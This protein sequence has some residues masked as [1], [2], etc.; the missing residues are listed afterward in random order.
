[1]SKRVIVLGAGLSG[2]SAAFSLV[3][4]GV[5]VVILE[6]R[7]RVGGRVETR[8]VNAS[9]DEYIFEAGAEWVGKNDRHILQMAKDFDLKLVDHVFDF[10]LEFEGEYKSQG[11][12]EFEIQAERKYQQ[13]LKDFVSGRLG[14]PEALDSISFWRFLAKNGFDQ[15][16]LI[17]RDLLYSSDFGESIRH[18]SAY[19]VLTVYSA[20][21]SHDNMDAK[22]LDGNDLLPKRLAEKI[23]HEKILL[24]SQVSAVKQSDKSVEVFSQNGGVFE[25]DYLICTLP[26]TAMLK[27]NWEPVFPEMQYDAM[28]KLEYA[29]VTKTAFVTSRKVVDKLNFALFTDQIP[30]VIY[31]GNKY[32]NDA[33]GDLIMSYSVGERADLMRT[34]SHAKL[35]EVMIEHLRK[36]F[37]IEVGELKFLDQKAW[38][39]DAYTAGAYSVFNIGHKLDLP[40]RLQNPFKRIFFAG[41]HLAVRQSFMEGAIESG[42]RVAEMVD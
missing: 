2:L 41:E 22:F 1:M 40:V 39:L 30:Q 20:A 16:E 19:G 3:K 33:K 4:R 42:L 35:E 29:R 23:G 14:S 26:T 34:M 31:H 15:R 11:N 12:W 8:R 10:G 25:A 32:S 5:E 36:E 17:M 7:G 9:G 27:V 38:E 18:V 28:E 13:I 21:T 24:N 6:A 37:K